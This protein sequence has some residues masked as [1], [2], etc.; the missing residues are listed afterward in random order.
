P[1]TP[2]TQGLDPLAPGPGASSVNAP[3]APTYATPPLNTFQPP[4]IEPFQ[5]APAP[6]LPST[7][8]TTPTTPTTP[9]PPGPPPAMTTPGAPPITGTSVPQSQTNRIGG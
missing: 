5:V 4:T 9:V 1:T 3:G 2:V 6:G 7:T 8:A